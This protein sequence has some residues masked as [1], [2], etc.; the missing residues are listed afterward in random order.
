M[1][2]TDPI[3]NHRDEKIITFLNDNRDDVER[4]LN[5]NY[6]FYRKQRIKN[7]RAWTLVVIY[8]VAPI[9]ILTILSLIMY[10]IVR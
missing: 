2:M 4:L 6:D 7:V 9:V 1:N 5:A 3:Y 10:A 8:A